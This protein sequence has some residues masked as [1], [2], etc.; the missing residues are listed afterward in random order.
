MEGDVDD[1]AA[2][3]EFWAG[4]E[5]LSSASAVDAAMSAT[6]FGVNCMYFSRAK[7]DNGH[8]TS[9]QFGTGLESGSW[10]RRGALGPPSQVRR[11]RVA[12]G[13][14]ARRWFRRRCRPESLPPQAH[15]VG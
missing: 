15:A 3:A 2:G 9:V 7:A 14:Q 8:R 1:G 5:R 13:D 10:L 11:G 6:P 12:G 4:A